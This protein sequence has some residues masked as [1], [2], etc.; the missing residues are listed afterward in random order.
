LENNVYQKMLLLK[1]KETLR[2]A[3]KIFCARTFFEQKEKNIKDNVYQHYSP[4]IVEN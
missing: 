2:S 4:M 3:K 1:E